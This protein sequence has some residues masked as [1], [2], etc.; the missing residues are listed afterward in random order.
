MKLKKWLAALIAPLAL[1]TSCIENKPVDY[2]QYVVGQWTLLQVDDG[3]FVT[4]SIKVMT[5]NPDFS[6]TYAYGKPT[7]DKQMIWVKEGGLTF[8]LACSTITLQSA[9]GASTSIKVKMK[10][11]I[12]DGRQM[13]CVLQDFTVN[14]V[15]KANN[16]LL[17]FEKSYVQLQNT[18]TGVWKTSRPNTNQDWYWDFKADGKYDFYIYDTQSQEYVKKII[19]KSTYDLYG[20]FL[21]AQYTDSATG[22]PLGE[23]ADVYVVES[24]STGG[25][26]L[27][28]NPPSGSAVV[29]TLSRT[30]LP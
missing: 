18:V 3:A 4:D 17:Y 21:V 14:G 23:S 15:Q 20:R 24:T 29:Y 28:N 5:I 2:L 11:Q 9:P 16:Q 10:I 13:M 6:V 25:L 19:G 1:L 8:N 7:G 22:G 27:R 30:T 26:V 12:I